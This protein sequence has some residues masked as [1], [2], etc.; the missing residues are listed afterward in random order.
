MQSLWGIFFLLFAFSFCF[1][2]HVCQKHSHTHIRTLSLPLSLSGALALNTRAKGAIN[3][4]TFAYTGAREKPTLAPD[5]G[6]PATQPPRS[7]VSQTSYV[8][9]CRIGFSTQMFTMQNARTHTH[10]LHAHTKQPEPTKIPTQHTVRLARFRG[11]VGWT[12]APDRNG[13]GGCCRNER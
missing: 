4:Q 13:C 5:T 12:R 7:F 6:E 11:W 10:S 9:F 2:L 8:R 3:T 1:A